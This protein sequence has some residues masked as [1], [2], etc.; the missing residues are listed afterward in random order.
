MTR[1][2]QLF[3]EPRQ[4]PWLDNLPR[5]YLQDGTLARFIASGVRSATPALGLD[6]N[7]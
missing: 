4:S 7:E 5:T 1:L 6:L 3:E 2:V